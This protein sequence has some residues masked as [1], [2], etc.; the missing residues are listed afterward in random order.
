MAREAMK[1]RKQVWTVRVI[2]FE[3]TPGAVRN[4]LPG[5][6]IEQLRYMGHVRELASLEDP[7][8]N[9]L[10][11]YCPDPKAHDTRIWAEQNAARMRSFGIDAA[12][13]PVWDAAE[14]EKRAIGTRNGPTEVIGHM[15][16]LN[17]PRI[18]PDKI[19]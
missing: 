4:C 11:F 10:E 5:V 14:S 2:N 19:R 15:E 17:R 12:A 1:P 7:P 18:S 16:R 13:A 9:V 6:W 8:R 3:D